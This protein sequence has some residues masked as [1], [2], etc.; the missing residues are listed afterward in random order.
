MK[1]HTENDTEKIDLAENRQGLFFKKFQKFS[2]KQLTK[3][4]Y[5]VIIYL[6]YELGFIIQVQKRRRKGYGKTR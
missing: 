2:K 1:N 6:N 4:F 5:K 3:P